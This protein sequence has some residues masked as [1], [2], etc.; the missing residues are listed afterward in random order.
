VKR[1][2]S[3]ACCQPQCLCQ[4]FMLVCAA[5][6]SGSVVT[7]NVPASELCTEYRLMICSGA[8]GRASAEAALAEKKI[9]ILERALQHHPGSDVLLLELL[10]LVRPA[11][12]SSML[13]HC[14]MCKCF[15]LPA[16]ALHHC[17]HLFDGS[18]ALLAGGTLIPSQHG[19]PG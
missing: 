8:R 19:L 16:A 3:V 13:R 10:R 18:A 15:Q 5:L 2:G 4:S 17:M 11:V 6:A 7:H 9:A 1:W 14:Y 12:T